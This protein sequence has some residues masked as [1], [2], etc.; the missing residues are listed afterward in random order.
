MVIVNCRKQGELIQW[1]DIII[2][3][4]IIRLFKVLPQKPI[5]VRKHENEPIDKSGEGA[6][7]YYYHINKCFW[8][9]LHN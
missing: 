8:L 4:Q 6:W 1:S 3:Y 7:P 5:A 2:Y 9:L